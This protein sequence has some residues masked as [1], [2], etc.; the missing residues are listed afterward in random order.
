MLRAIGVSLNE[1]EELCL[2]SV[3]QK[4]QLGN[5]ISVEELEEI[6]QSVNEELEELQ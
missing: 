2:L 6:M 3:L 1:Q 4:P 5:N